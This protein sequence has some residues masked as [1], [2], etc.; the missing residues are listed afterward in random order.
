MNLVK[1]D[2]AENMKM[3][4][5]R[6]Q[7]ARLRRALT[8]QELADSTGVSLRSI[9]VWEKGFTNLP[10]PA[11]LRRL[12]EVLHVSPD[13][14]HGADGNILTAPGAFPPVPDWLE[15]LYLRLA[16]LEAQQRDEVVAALV[17]VVAA[18]M[19]RKTPCE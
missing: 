19:G 12:C 13:Y 14:L 2:R 18:I 8:Q 6:L 16:P 4:G 1:V 10:R 7:T 11:F 15:P 17:S 3:F 5:K 9:Q